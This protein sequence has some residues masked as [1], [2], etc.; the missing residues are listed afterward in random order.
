MKSDNDKAHVKRS[1]PRPVRF[2][3]FKLNKILIFILILLI[4]CGS[5]FYADYRRTVSG[6]KLSPAELTQLAIDNTFSAQTYRFQSKST[7][8]VGKE[9]RVFSVFEGEKSDGKRHIEGNILG[10][11]LNIFHIDDTTYQQDAASGQWYLIDNTGLE[12]SSLLINELDPEKD[13]H[14]SSLGETVC[15]GNEKVNG[16]SVKVM[17]FHPTLEDKWIVKYFTDITY[18]IKIS[19]GRK[20]YIINSVTSAVSKENDQAKLVIENYFSDFGKEIEITAPVIS[21]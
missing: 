7:L 12:A 1:I 6:S 11:P 15:K 4:A 13:F 19:I 20:P 3:S 16:Q 9:E 14:F 8:Y 18:T 17:E 21:P 5:F 10:T 2:Q